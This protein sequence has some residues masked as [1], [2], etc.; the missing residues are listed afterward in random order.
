VGVT[1]GDDLPP[2]QRRHTVLLRHKRT[3]LPAM[4]TIE[5]VDPELRALVTGGFS[6]FVQLSNLVVKL[7]EVLLFITNERLDICVYT[8]PMVDPTDQDARI[9]SDAEPDQLS[10]ARGVIVWVLISTVFWVLVAVAVL[11]CRLTSS[12]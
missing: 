7:R 1:A 5:L 3:R 11:W 12:R 2:D 4:S 8:D 10:T 9:E 6:R